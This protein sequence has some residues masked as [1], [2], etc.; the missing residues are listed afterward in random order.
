MQKFAITHTD[1]G[2]VHYLVMFGYDGGNWHIQFSSGDL[3]R[4]VTLPDRHSA[5][6]LLNFIL[7]YQPWFAGYL[8]V[9]EV[10]LDA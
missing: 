1:N 2:N 9:E 6:S 3:F 4:P 5:Y 10:D 7:A 8:G